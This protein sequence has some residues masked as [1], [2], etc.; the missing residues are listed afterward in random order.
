MLQSVRFWVLAIV[1]VWMSVCIAPVHAEVWQG[2]GQVVSG[3]GTGAAVSL[4]VDYD[5]QKLKA[6]SGPPLE[7]SQVRIDQQGDVL[8]L[9]IFRGNQVVKYRLKRVAPG[10]ETPKGN[11]QEQSR[12]PSPAA[13]IFSP[14]SG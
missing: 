8:E 6:L 5:G 14:N 12:R 3:P 1:F 10:G 4:T 2:T 13:R 7:G 9:T 11:P